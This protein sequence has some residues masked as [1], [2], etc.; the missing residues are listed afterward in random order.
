MKAIRVLSNSQKTAALAVAST[1]LFSIVLRA[2]GV[3]IRVSSNI[4]STIE[5]VRES[6]HF[7]EINVSEGEKRLHEVVMLSS[8]SPDFERKAKR[9]FG[10][11]MCPDHFIV[12][13]SYDRIYVLNDFS[14]AHYY[15]GSLF[16]ALL[17][18]ELFDDFL[19]VHGA[20]LI[21][22]EG[23]LLPGA[24][25]CG[26][27]T[28]TLSLLYRGFKFA[29]DDIII[30]N[31]KDL[32]VYPY[33]RLLNIRR[34]SLN[35]IP[36]LHRDYPRMTFSYI[37]GEPR[38]FLD[39]TE[40]VAEPFLCQ[41]ILF[42]QWTSGMSRLVEISKANAGMRMIQH[43]FYPLTPIK[44]CNDSS[45]NLKTVAEVVKSTNTYLLLQA[46]SAD[47]VSCLLDYVRA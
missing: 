30:L 15:T 2:H 29:T 31:R 32:K 47:G 17:E 46:N 44:F 26:K 12:V 39:R 42:P 27:T 20:A 40:S 3:S 28:L 14:E 22:D 16:T 25:R 21:K 13:T 11:R 5:S 34:E 8:N 6:Y 33:P 9:I 36:E 18:A 1:D 7:F 35:M 37:F 43:S 41:H 38:W 24:L 10:T 19:I 23:I 4:K 45:L